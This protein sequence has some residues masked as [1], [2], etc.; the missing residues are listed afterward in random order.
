MEDER[1]RGRRN[2]S[3]NQC[4]MEGM[5]D[6][7]VDIDPDSLVDFL[8]GNHE[9]GMKALVKRKLDQMKKGKRGMELFNWIYFFFA[10]CFFSSFFGLLSLAIA[11]T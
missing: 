7:Q 1:R 4:S 9:E 10:G 8:R 3:F 6:S 5:Q 11:V 2:K